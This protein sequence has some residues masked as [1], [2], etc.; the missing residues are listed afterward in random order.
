MLRITVELVPL[1]DEDRKRKIGE[2]VIANDGAGGYEAWTAP[3]KWSSEPARYGV[4]KG[5]DRSQS[6]WELIRI[7]LECIRLEKHKIP[8]KKDSLAQRLKRVLSWY[9]EHD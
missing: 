9:S 2:M 6:V 3:D 7:M 5:Y 4:L 1:G 8:R